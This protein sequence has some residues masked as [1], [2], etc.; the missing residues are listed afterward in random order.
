MSKN[1]LELSSTYLAA[2]EITQ[3]SG[4]MYPNS[5]VRGFLKNGKKH[6]NYI[7]LKFEMSFIV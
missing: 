5:N 3:L 6:A 1:D 7:I 2:T 4:F